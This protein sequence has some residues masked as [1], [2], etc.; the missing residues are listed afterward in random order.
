MPPKRLMDN[1]DA[2]AV[3][4]V[5]ADDAAQPAVVRADDGA[6]AQAAKRV[7]A[8]GE[9]ASAAAK[10]SADAS[11]AYDLTEMIDD[12]AAG[13]EPRW[14]QLNDGGVKDLQEFDRQ[15]VALLAENNVLT[16]VSAALH[17][18]SNPTDPHCV[19]ERKLARAF[20]MLVRVCDDAMHAV[21]CLGTYGLRD[22]QAAIVAG[23]NVAGHAFWRQGFA[24]LTA[25]HHHCSAALELT[26]S[27]V[28]VIS[29]Q[30]ASCGITGMVEIARLVHELASHS[31]ERT[32]AVYQVY[33]TWV[34]RQVRQT[35][36]EAQYRLLCVLMRFVRHCLCELPQHEGDHDPFRSPLSRAHLDLMMRGP[37]RDAFLDEL[38]ALLAADTAPARRAADYLLSGD[39]AIFMVVLG[40]AMTTERY[41]ARLW[42]VLRDIAH[43]QA[44]FAERASRIY[45]DFWRYLHLALQ[46]EGDRAAP[47]QD[48]A[49]TELVATVVYKRPIEPE[50]SAQLMP[51]V[52]AALVRMSYDRSKREDEESWCALLNRLSDWLRAQGGVAAAEEAA[53][54]MPEFKRLRERWSHLITQA[55]CAGRD[56]YAAAVCCCKR[57]GAGCTTCA[58]QL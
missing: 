38:S 41:D 20:A 13:R 35:Q 57:M 47:L 43:S 54:T 53:S 28:H 48:L 4:V 7:A 52:F 2:A 34:R 27:L 30:M 42:S 36:G 32:V 11:R 49:T 14:L 19:D 21:P 17:K 6:A 15:M 58:C 8:G 40:A 45:S 3:A 44:D 18:L 22:L 50:Q 33:G 39:F 24:A 46:L 1:D 9:S 25:L 56:A 5:H 51:L 12:G 26:P 55:Q 37:V 10:P 23:L 16:Q 29:S 31:S